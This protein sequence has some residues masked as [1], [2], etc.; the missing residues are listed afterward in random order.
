[1]IQLA[2]GSL[3]RVEEM[4][5]QD[6]LK[7]LGSCPDLEVDLSVV[8]KIEDR[9]NGSAYITLAV[10]AGNKTINNNLVIP[11]KNRNFT[12]E[13]PLEHPFFIYENGW[14]SCSPDKTRDRYGLEVRK[15]SV[16]DPCLS[17]KPL[18]RVK[19]SVVNS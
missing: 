19:E 7:C 12:V 1:M 13:T 4:K 16:G 10:G 6:F 8:V 2:D 9:G 15:L 5:T 11:S 18:N 3:R 14:S 17:L